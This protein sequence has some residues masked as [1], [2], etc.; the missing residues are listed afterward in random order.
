ME[1]VFNDSAVLPV[2]P[3]LLKLEGVNEMTISNEAIEKASKILKLNECEDREDVRAIRN[4]IVRSIHSLKR[5]IIN[6]EDKS[7]IEDKEVKDILIN[8]LGVVYDKYSM[9]L[10]ALTAVCDDYMWKHFGSV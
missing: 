4:S 5:A 2:L 3:E 6:A 7:G 1:R 9:Y 10:S 8:D